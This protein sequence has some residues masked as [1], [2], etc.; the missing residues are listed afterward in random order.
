[1]DGEDDF[2]VSLEK[3]WGCPRD[4][5]DKGKWEN[6][7]LLLNQA[8]EL[9]RQIERQPKRRGRKPKLG[10]KKNALARR[11]VGRPPTHTLEDDVSFYASV[12][13]TRSLLSRDQQ[14]SHITTKAAI[15]HILADKKSPI[16]GRGREVKRLQARHS[17]IKSRYFSNYKNTPK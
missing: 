8:R 5:W 4:T 11:R 12:E 6:A 16:S 7:A 1:M 13:I 15:A 2:F 14:G 3:V 17:Q 9:A 10:G